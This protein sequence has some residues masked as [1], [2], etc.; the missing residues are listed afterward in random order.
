MIVVGYGSELIRRWFEYRPYDGISVTL[1]ENRDYHKS[2]GISAL[3]A[4]EHINGNFLLLMADHV[5]EPETAAALVEQP[6]APGEVILAVDPSINRVFDI[7]DATKVR[8]DGNFIVDIGKNLVSYD[9]LDTGMF[10][11]SRALFAHLEAVAGTGIAHCPTACANSRVLASSEPGRLAIGGGT[12]L[13]RRTLCSMLNLPLMGNSGRRPSLG[14]WPVS[15]FLNSRAIRS[16]SALLGIALL[17]YLV[18]RTGP[19]NILENIRTL[20]W[21]LALIVALGGLAHIV[22]AWAWKLTLLQEKRHVSFID[23]SGCVW[24]RRLPGS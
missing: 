4:K 14:T 15:R 9:A 6:L 20:G 24:R 18:W 8:R 19:A 3:K 12:I 1:V 11:C 13:T 22:K 2:N 16:A 10:L 23:F 17:A 7:D 21:G 5:F